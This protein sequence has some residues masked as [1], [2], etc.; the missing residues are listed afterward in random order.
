[1]CVYTNREKTHNSL[2]KTQLNADVNF[3]K[4]NNNNK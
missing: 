2:N 4:N 1:M 3:I